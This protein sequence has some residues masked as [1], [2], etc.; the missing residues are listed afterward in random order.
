ME[1]FGSFFLVELILYDG[2]T[3]GCSVGFEND[4]DYVGEAWLLACEAGA[5]GFVG[6]EDFSVRGG[7]EVFA[8]E[9]VGD[10]L[11]GIDA[12]DKGRGGQMR[13]D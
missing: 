11:A 12:D 9:R 4:F 3:L 13:G 6:D 10:V 8:H 7:G 5:G 1:N 2:D